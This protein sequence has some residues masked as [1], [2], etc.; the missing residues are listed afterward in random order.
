MFATI[1]DSETKKTIFNYTYEWKDIEMWQGLVKRFGRDMEVQGENG[2]VRAWGVFNFHETRARYL[3]SSDV[4]FLLTSFISSIE[5][6]LRKKRL[7]NKLAF[8]NA[9][10][11]ASLEFDEKDVIQ[12]WCSNQVTVALTSYVSPPDDGDISLLVSMA[13][14]NGIQSIRQVYV[15]TKQFQSWTYLIYLLRPIERIDPEKAFHFLTA[16]V[17]ALKRAV[18]LEKT[19]ARCA[20]S[21]DPQSEA[22]GM[23]DEFIRTC[24]DSAGKQWNVKTSWPKPFHFP[25]EDDSNQRRQTRVLNLIK[26]CFLTCQMNT[27]RALLDQVWNVSG[28]VVDKFNEIYTPLIP[29]LCKLLRKTNIDVYTPPFIDFFRL[30]ISHY[31][32]YVLGTKGQQVQLRKIGCGCAD[33]RSLDDFMLGMR[34]SQYTFRI[35]QKTV[36][37]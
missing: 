36:V 15:S 26:L 16:L 17:K 3:C 12:D 14:E 7:P 24:L 9:I 30:L 21:S 33:C 5:D 35:T 20:G 4:R 2:L 37:I 31:L 6:L 34:Q 22:A 1:S 32:C 18:I 25:F 29:E 8:I 19:V 13:C 27:C 11:Q 10:R 23:L 28:E